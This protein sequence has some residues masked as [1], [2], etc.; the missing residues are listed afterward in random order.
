MNRMQGTNDFD[1][2]WN[3]LILNFYWIIVLAVLIAEVAALL[4]TSSYQLS[5]LPG[6]LVNKLGL[7]SILQLAIMGSCEFMI[8]RLKRVG[9]Y[10][11]ILAGTALSAVLIAADPTVD[12][13]KYSLLLPMMISLFY[14]QQ[15]KLIFALSANIVALAAFYA[16][17][18]RP[19]QFGAVYDLA[20][21]A[22]IMLGAF[23]ILCGLLRRGKEVSRHLSKAIQSEQDLLIRTV[24]MDRQ[25]K[26]D[27]LTDLYNHKTFHEYLDNLVAQSDQHGLPLQLAIIDIDNFKKVNDTFG[28]AVG[29]VILQR[30]A[31][32]IKQSLST[33]DDIAARYGGEEFAIIF[34]DKLP[35][36]SLGNIEVI[37]TQIEA[38]SHHEMNGKCVTVSVGLASYRS[39]A[40]RT[41]LFSEAD[42]MLYAAKRGGKN[43][44]VT[45]L[46]PSAV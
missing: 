12:G 44:T 28:H 30:V 33:S 17:H 19:L 2:S 21:F 41:A 5:D 46:Q 27:A 10:L 43:R 18:P 20:A 7:P 31:Q 11:I 14:D 8:P 37:R 24:I 29:D 22:V 26:F 40:G 23:I 34:T 45:E 6:V 42:S 3:R 16:I 35:E 4:M 38:L 39:G 1:N 15:R 36:Q 25:T 32:I 9:A 13:I